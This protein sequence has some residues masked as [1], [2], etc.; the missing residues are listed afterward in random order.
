MLPNPHLEYGKP[1]SI[2]TG[3]RGSWNLNNVEFFK[4]AQIGSWAVMDFTGRN[5]AEENGLNGFVR[6]LV[7]MMRKMGMKV[8]QAFPPCIRGDMRKIK[9]SLNEAVIQSK[10]TYGQNKPNFVLVV[11]P[12]AD[13]LNYQVFNI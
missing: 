6:A 1:K 4:G 5:M 7:E 2:N 13:A 3:N 12:N 11:L 8:P 9:D 10:N